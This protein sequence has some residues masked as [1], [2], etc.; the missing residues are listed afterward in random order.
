MGLL[1]K[2]RFFN[3]FDHVLGVR[4]IPKFDLFKNRKKYK[5]FFVITEYHDFIYAYY[6]ITMRIMVKW[7][8][9]YLMKPWPLFKWSQCFFVR[10]I[11]SFVTTISL[12]QLFAWRSTSEIIFPWGI[13]LF[14]TLS[15]LITLR[16]IAT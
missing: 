6:M 8:C 9:R 14:H 12:H 16:F 5:S 13:R 2:T 1:K 15:L 11:F 10:S 3:V 4:T 7:T